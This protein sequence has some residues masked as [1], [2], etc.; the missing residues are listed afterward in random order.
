MLSG[1]R[2]INFAR[3]RIRSSC[4]CDLASPRKTSALS[5]S[6]RQH[7]R[8]QGSAHLPL[9]ETKLTYFSTKGSCRFR[10]L[11]II[12][13]DAGGPMVGLGDVVKD[14]N[15]YTLRSVHPEAADGAARFS[16]QWWRELV[17]GYRFPSACA[18]VG[19]CSRVWDLSPAFLALSISLSLSLCGGPG[20]AVEKKKWPRYPSISI[21]RAK[22]PAAL[23]GCGAPW[24]GRVGVWTCG[25]AESRGFF[26]VRE[27][28]TPSRNLFPLRRP[29]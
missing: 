12:N 15:Q 16:E 28:T 26:K 25:V 29:I 1:R 6:Q 5:V 18:H 17:S 27:I 8:I 4:S 13:E 24:L 11:I 23:R 19:P 2:E 10:C 14:L 7:T 21:Y 3:S 9:K 22:I 20:L